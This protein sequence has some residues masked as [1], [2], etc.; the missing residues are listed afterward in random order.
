MARVFKSIL[1][2]APHR[3]Y[4]RS[5][6][7]AA[8]IELSLELFPGISGVVEARLVKNNQSLSGLDWQKMKAEDKSF[9]WALKD[10]PMGGP[11]ALEL[12]VRSGSQVIAGRRIPGILVGDLWILA[13][14]SNMDGC[15]KLDHIETPSAYVHCFYH[16]DNWGIAK[17]P[18]CIVDAS[19]DPVHWGIADAVERAKAVKNH[20]AFGEIGGGLGVRFGKDLYKATGVPV[21]LVMC[22]HGGTSLGQWDPALKDQGGNS[23]YGSMMRR[24]GLVGGKAAGFL[25]YQGESDAHLDE[26]SNYKANF[27]R[28]IESVR[29]DFGQPDLPFLYV[30]LAKFYSDEATYGTRW[31]GVQNDQLL[32]EKE[33]KNIAVATAIDC[34]ISDIIH[35]DA[36][37]Q[38]KMG[39]RLAKLA[40]RIKFGHKIE[41]G[42]RPEKVEFTDS[43]RTVIRV[44]YSSVNGALT[45]A[46][47]IRG[48][49]VEK[50]GIPCGIKS[51]VRESDG[52]SVIIKLAWAVPEGANLWYGRGLNPCVNLAD[53]GG[54]AAPVFGPVE[55]G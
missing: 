15:G 10:V 35:I 37:S 33:M 46:R 50:E 24:F 2:A 1:G 40:R 29:S 11:Y 39:A 32:I 45:P 16:D 41:V 18:L 43:A 31:N 36:V 55:V 44:T 27:R 42:P 49:L 8:N 3:V 53:R 20:K 5:D 12:R 38:R 14:Q 6:R 17:D 23:F 54:F 28:F 30:Q 26:W 47:G 25:W 52:K 21:G 22:S 9:T 7:N 4:Q 19:K 48:F 13:G 51:C 34:T